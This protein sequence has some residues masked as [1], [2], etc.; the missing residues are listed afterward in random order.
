MPVLSLNHH[1]KRTSENVQKSEVL[2][3]FK[4]SS[5]C[6]FLKKRETSYKYTQSF[7]KI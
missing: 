1:L 2:K 6:F 7:L 3:N 4:G 5:V